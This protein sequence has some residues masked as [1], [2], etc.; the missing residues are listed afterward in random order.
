MNL[1]WAKRFDDDVNDLHDTFKSFP[2]RT[3]SASPE[4]FDQ[5][6]KLF[7]SWRVHILP[8]IDQTAG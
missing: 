5:N 4:S 3:G 1:W 6:G 7:L 2:V 8:F